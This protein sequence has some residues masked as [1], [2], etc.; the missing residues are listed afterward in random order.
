MAQSFAFS[1]RIQRYLAS[2]PSTMLRMVPLPTR[3]ARGED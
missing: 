3:S 1:R 2:Y